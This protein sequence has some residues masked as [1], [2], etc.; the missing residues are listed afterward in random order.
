MKELKLTAII[1]FFLGFDKFPGFVT[2]TSRRCLGSS[3]VF[4]I[5]STGAAKSLQYLRPNLLPEKRSPV[6]STTGGR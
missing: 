6:Q 1:S 2:V 5:E 3:V 4:V